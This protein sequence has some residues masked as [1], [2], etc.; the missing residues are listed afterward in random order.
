MYI[1]AGYS[2]RLGGSGKENQALFKQSRGQKNKLHRE[3]R[4]WRAV[5]PRPSLLGGG[6]PKLP[7]CCQYRQRREVKEYPEQ[8]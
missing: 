1:G 2:S 4:D 5:R 6:A 7:G 8:S 3:A